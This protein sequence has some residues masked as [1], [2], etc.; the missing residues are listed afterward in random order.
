MRPGQKERPESAPAAPTTAGVALDAYWASF[1][2]PVERAQERAR[3]LSK[4]HPEMQQLELII[5]SDDRVLVTN[6]E[7]YPWRCVCSL[8]ITAQSGTMY[9]GTGWLVSPRV[10]L[11]A[12][13]C[14]Y[15]SDEGGWAS[16]IE[17]IPGRFG[18]KRPFGSAISRELRSVTGF[19]V[20]NDRVFLLGVGSGATMAMDVGA[21]HPD[22]FA[23]VI[24]VGPTPHP[25]VY[26]YYYKNAQ[27]LPFYV[28]TGSQAGPALQELRRVFE[29]WMPRG[30]PAIMSVYKG[31]GAE[32]FPGET[33]VM[34]E[35]MSRK[36]RPT[37][38]LLRSFSSSG[39]RTAT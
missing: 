17:V 7:L 4:Q 37:S 35:W 12:G 26:R 30:Y 34:F 5:G 10:V 36:R 6:N 19:T 3:I 11:T 15:M 33:P 9:L 38:F 8:L 13:H 14:V 32:W 20:D 29:E 1:G 25:W 21:S 2:T 39:R 22:L 23:G 18:D 31:R 16:Q 27:K 28:V 24:A